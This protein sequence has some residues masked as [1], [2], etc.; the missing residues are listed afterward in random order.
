[1][2]Q[3]KKLDNQSLFYINTVGTA[4]AVISSVALLPQVFNVIL[5]KNVEGL[6]LS[7]TLL[8]MVT[9]ALWI[10]YHIK[11]GTY[12]PLVSASFNFIFAGI[13]SYYI[14]SIRN[15]QTNNDYV[16]FKK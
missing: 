9:T 4:A 7:T 2:S 5:T 11:M 1:M 8:I 3:V 16:L 13:L 14:I 15:D 6:S 12:P 10:F